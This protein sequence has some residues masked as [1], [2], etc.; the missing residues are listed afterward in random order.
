MISFANSSPFSRSV[1]NPLSTSEPPAFSVTSTMQ[2]PAF[3]VRHKPRK[4]TEENMAWLKEEERKQAAENAERKLP[5]AYTGS[6]STAEN[7]RSFYGNSH[8]SAMQSH[9]P[10]S[11]YTP[12]EYARIFAGK[13]PYGGAKTRKR[14]GKYSKKLRKYKSRRR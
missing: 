13:L 11:G 9:L 3:N 12:K 8:R 4:I 7:A 6:I 5:P 14:N 10:G 1:S 2:N